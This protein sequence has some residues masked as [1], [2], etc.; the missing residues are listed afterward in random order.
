MAQHRINKPKRREEKEEKNEKK[1][2][3]KRKLNSKGEINDVYVD[4]DNSR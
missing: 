3:K 1:K 4:D 2:R